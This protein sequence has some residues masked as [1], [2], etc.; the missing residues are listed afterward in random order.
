MFPHKIS[1]P[2]YRKNDT[3]ED[4]I[5]FCDGSHAEILQGKNSIAHCHPIFC[6]PNYLLL[7]ASLF[8]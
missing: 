4:E 6:P 2:I 8:K 3:S 1:A 5:I 7:L